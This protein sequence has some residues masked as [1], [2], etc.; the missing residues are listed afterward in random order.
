MG[1]LRP[2]YAG[3]G[4]HHHM[5]TTMLAHFFLWHLKIHVGKK[6]P[7]AH[8]VTSAAAPGSGLTLVDVLAL[9]AWR[10][11]RNHSAYL[12]HRKRRETEG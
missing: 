2:P 9:L 8:G 12:S 10:Q 6:S 7:G 3:A 1:I 5:L 4:W 11:R